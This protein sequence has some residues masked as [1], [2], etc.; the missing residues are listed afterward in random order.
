MTPKVAVVI[1]NAGVYDQVADCVRSIQASTQLDHEIVVV[2][3]VVDHIQLERLREKLGD[4]ALWL[5]MERNVGFGPA[6]NIGAGKTSAPFLL[7][8]NP[9]TVVPD[10]ALDNLVATLDRHAEVGI[11]GPQLIN[12]D[13]SLQ[14]TAYAMYP[15]LRAMCL[16]ALGLQ[17]WWRVARSYR[18]VSHRNG[19]LQSTAWLKGACILVRRSVWERLNGFDESFFMFGEDADLCRRTKDLGFDV[20]LLPAV[21]VTHLGGQSYIR[22]G[23]REQAVR[24]FYTSYELAV[25]RS[26]DNSEAPV[27]RRVLRVAMW[28]AA[29]SRAA[30]LGVSGVRKSARRPDALAYWRYVRSPCR[31][32]SLPTRTF[33]SRDQ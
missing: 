33:D 22:G 5:P 11:V 30:Y 26:M 18:P 16:D 28:A 19:D 21:R 14:T 23:A 32:P 15:S 13:G 4:G 10:S 17:H 20:A 6:N 24:D 27:R 2:D 1:V 12:P 8:L 9:D 25:F 7:F 31:P 3:N 29:L